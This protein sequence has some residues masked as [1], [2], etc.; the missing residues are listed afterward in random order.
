M[1][2]P[3]PGRTQK[4]GFMMPDP[5][6]RFVDT[7][8]EDEVQLHGIKIHFATNDERLRHRLLSLAPKAPG[9]D[10]CM[11]SL[12]I[13]VDGEEQD[14]STPKPLSLHSFKVKSLGYITIGTLG[15]IAYD[16]TEHMAFSFVKS[17]LVIKDEL[18]SC[19]F[20]P[21]FKSALKFA[22]DHSD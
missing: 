3:K 22:T 13:V 12:K 19:Y 10:D 14:T 17:D 5:S 6:R 8:I 11:F 16:K 18:F 15:F 4:I 1:F 9:T 20:L 7:P 21:A 2:L